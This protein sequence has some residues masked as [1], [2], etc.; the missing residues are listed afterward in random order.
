MGL[1]QGEIGVKRSG[2]GGSEFWFTLPLLAASD[3][4]FSQ[5]IDAQVERVVVA[6]RL[7]SPTYQE[8]WYQLLTNWGFHCVLP[9]STEDL[10]KWLDQQLADKTHNICLLD[11]RVLVDVLTHNRDSQLNWETAI[12]IYEFKERSYEFK[13]SSEE[14]KE[15]SQPALSSIPAEQLECLP[16]FH[17]KAALSLTQFKAGLLEVQHLSTP[18]AASSSQDEVDMSNTRILVAEDN[19]VNQ[20]VIKGMLKK[21]K[22]TCMLANDGEEVRQYYCENPDAYDLI[23]MDWEMPVL[24]GISATRLIREWELN[25][26][27]PPIPIIALTAHALASYEEVALNA[28]MQGYLSKPIMLNTLAT[29]MKGIL[30]TQAKI[31]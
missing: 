2:S 30:K 29:T 5:W 17:I 8:Q 21:L 28:G 22:A 31:G 6:L 27:R 1:M 12:F 4:P 7:S 16:L 9:A 20:M 3:Y 11:D 23:L 15:N 18:E 19:K 13:E 14:F 26:H 24:D 10:T 25:H